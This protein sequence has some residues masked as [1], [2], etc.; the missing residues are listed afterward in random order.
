[1]ALPLC[2]KE[3]QQHIALHRGLNY[4]LRI[5]L[6]NLISYSSFRNKRTNILFTATFLIR[7]FNY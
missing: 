6:H 1:M 7:H 5:M 2:G 3:Y 4:L